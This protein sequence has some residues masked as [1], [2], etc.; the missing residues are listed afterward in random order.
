[1]ST[2]AVI[3][4]LSGCRLPRIREDFMGGAPLISVFSFIMFDTF[5][6]FGT[7]FNYLPCSSLVVVHLVAE[8]ILQVLFSQS[9]QPPIGCKDHLINDC[10]WAYALLVKV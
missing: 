6:D 7:N 1:M 8:E 10:W 4:N 2:S 9:L 5:Q 3:F